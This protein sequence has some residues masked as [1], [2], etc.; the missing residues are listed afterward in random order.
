MSETEVRPALIEA[1]TFAEK[2]LK[3]KPSSFAGDDN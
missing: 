2:A 1:T 3:A